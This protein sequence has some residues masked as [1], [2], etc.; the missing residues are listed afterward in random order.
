MEAL[1]THCHT[2]FDEPLN[3]ASYVA[4]PPLPP[5]PLG[6][7]AP[8][9]PYGSA[10]T[11]FSE[12]VAQQF[13]APLPQTPTPQSTDDDFTP[14]LPTRPPASIHPSSRGN[15]SSSNGHSNASPVLNEAEAHVTSPTSYI[16]PPPLPLRPGRQGALT[17]IQSLRGTRGLDFS[18]PEISEGDWT[19]PAPASPPLSDPPSL[20]SSAFKSS[21]FPP[22]TPPPALSQSTF[23]HQQQRL[24][25]IQAQA[26]EESQPKPKPILP[27]VEKTTVEDFDPVTSPLET[28]LSAV[29]EDGHSTDHASFII[30]DAQTR[31]NLQPS[32]PRSLAQYGP[33]VPIQVTQLQE[34]HKPTPVHPARQPEEVPQGSESQDNDSPPQL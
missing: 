8:P 27:P 32:T 26:Q 25:L 16:S 14:Q 21:Q 5:A 30:P 1:I 20:P 17:P 29:V 19:G 34:Q 23:A 15:T 13:S 33:Q 6:E 3:A 28:S 11:K 7:T 9:Y 4:S 22:L 10:H 12:Y 31:P 24:A 18:Q 2:I